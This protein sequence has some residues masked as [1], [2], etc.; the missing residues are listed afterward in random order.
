MKEIPEE[1]VIK[2][3]TA[4]LGQSECKTEKLTIDEFHRLLE[5]NTEAMNEERENYIRNTNELK[6]FSDGMKDTADDQE[7]DLNSRRE[8]FSATIADTLQ[9]FKEEARNIRDFR[10]KITEDYLM[11]VAKEKGRHAKENE[12]IS[13]ERHNIFE[14][15]RNSGGA[16]GRYQRPISP[17][18][19]QNQQ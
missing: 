2:N 3:E 19:E 10:R 12:R 14:R 15:W 5:K 8:E 13:S 18:M 16:T 11:N 17:S 6:R 4:Q 1:N 9:A 7:K